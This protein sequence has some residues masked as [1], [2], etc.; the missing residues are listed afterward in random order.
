M[1]AIEDKVILRKLLVSFPLQKITSPK[2]AQAKGVYCGNSNYFHVK[3][4]K[5]EHRVIFP[6]APHSKLTEFHSFR[7][8]IFSVKLK[9]P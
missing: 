9:T 1:L 6:H 7:S 4:H 8:D 3:Q 2:L 5:V